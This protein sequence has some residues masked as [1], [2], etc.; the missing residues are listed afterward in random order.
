MHT[1]CSLKA[2]KL[3]PIPAYTTAYHT[4]THT[5]NTVLCFK[6]WNTV[7]LLQCMA[8]VLSFKEHLVW[9]KKKLY[10][11]HEHPVGFW[12]RHN[13]HKRYYFIQACV[14]MVWLPVVKEMNGGNH[15]SIKFSK[16]CSV[17]PK[18]VFA[19]FIQW[20]RACVYKK[21]AL[22]STDDLYIVCA[23]LCTCTYRYIHVHVHMYLL[24]H[25]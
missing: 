19:Y 16:T 25:M 10:R 8:T 22:R 12:R 9:S 2:N 23:H 6:V 17:P 3:N 14:L 1:I 7:I 5:V 13:T 15:Y 24:R 21:S 20:L 11:N 18:N 4:H